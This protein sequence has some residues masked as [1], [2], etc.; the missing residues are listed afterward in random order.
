MQTK[1]Y[2]SAVKNS[3]R[4]LNYSRYLDPQT[5]TPQAVVQVPQHEFKKNKNKR[6]NLTAATVNIMPQEF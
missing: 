5:L 6:G 3:K 1:D 2:L 4:K